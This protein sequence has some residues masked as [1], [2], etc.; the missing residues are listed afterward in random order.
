VPY[1]ARHIE[2]GVSVEEAGGLSMKPI[3][4]TGITGQ[5]SGRTTWWARILAH[6]RNAMTR[7]MFQ[8]FIAVTVPPNRA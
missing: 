7:E 5:S 6:Q 8:V 4:A 2:G 1:R 3:V